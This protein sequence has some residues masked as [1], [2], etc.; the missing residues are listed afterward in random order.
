MSPIPSP[1]AEEPVDMTTGHDSRSPVRNAPL[2]TPAAGHRRFRRRSPAFRVRRY[3]TA[4]LQVAKDD[5]IDFEAFLQHPSA[6]HMVRHQR[7]TA[8]TSGADDA[9]NAEVTDHWAHRCRAF[10]RYCSHRWRDSG[11]FLRLDGPG[12]RRPDRL[13]SGPAWLSSSI[14]ILSPVFHGRTWLIFVVLLAAFQWMITARVIRS[15]TLS[16]K[17]REF[18][19]AARFMGDARTG[20]S[21]AAQHPAEYVF[22]SD[23][24]M[25]PLMSAA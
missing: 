23:H 2:P 6:T 12:H 20:R 13:D 25:P 1:I 10:H 4:F 9:G 16:M 15:M 11:L 3:R 5:Q 8:S 7:K 22:R 24:L 18:V 14:A 21:F 19:Y 17:E